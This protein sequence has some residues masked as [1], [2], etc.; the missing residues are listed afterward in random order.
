MT[1]SNALPRS[2]TGGPS[3]SRRGGIAG[4]LGYADVALLATTTAAATPAAATVMT[5]RGKLP[6]AS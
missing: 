1:A 4:A 5:S 3:L 6:S 2:G